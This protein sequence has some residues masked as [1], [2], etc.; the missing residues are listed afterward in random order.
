MC[1]KTVEW[2]FVS[3][4]SSDEGP[5]VAFRLDP[6]PG[7]GGSAHHGW[8][9]ARNLFNLGNFN[10]QVEHLID[11]PSYVEVSIFV[12]LGH[13]ANP[14]DWPRGIL[15]ALWSLTLLRVK[16]F[17]IS[18]CVVLCYLASVLALTFDFAR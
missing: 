17:R 10:N 7:V 9:L 11:E 6:V 14:S 18:H 2:L 4:D 12:D 15:P 1:L 8:L 16:R 13:T 3:I 5:T